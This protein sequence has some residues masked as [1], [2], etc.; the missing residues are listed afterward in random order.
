VVVSLLTPAPA[1]RKLAGLTF[2]TVDE[3]M[4]TSEVD[5]ILLRSEYKPAPET[6]AERR[7]NITFS[8]LLTATVFGLWVYFR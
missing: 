8:V 1:R 2:A 4:D 5:P 7:I 3:K 6:P